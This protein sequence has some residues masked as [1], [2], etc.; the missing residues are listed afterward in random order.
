MKKC[1]FTEE[2]RI[3]LLQNKNIEKICNSSVFFTA[4]FKIH[5]IK[6]HELGDVA[7]II[8]KEAKIP[9]WLNKKDYARYCIKFWRRVY[10]SD[11]TSAFRKIKVKKNKTL[12]EMNL[13]ELMTKVAYLEEENEFLKKLNALETL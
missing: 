11:P 3:E 1:C 8:F 4:D 2:Q 9:D 13:E 5:A 12:S 6:R 10:R 7:R